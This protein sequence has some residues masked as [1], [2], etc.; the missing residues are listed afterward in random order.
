VGPSEIRGSASPNSVRPFD[1]NTTS[2]GN[3]VS[4]EST[5]K[6]IAAFILG[7]L[8][9]VTAVVAQTAHHAPSSP[10]RSPMSAVA[11]AP[12]PITVA[13]NAGDVEGFVYW[14]VNAITHNP[15]GSCSG[16][17]VNVSVAGAS[18]PPIQTG[19]H[20]KYA[21]QVKAFLYG[22]KQTI[23]DVCIYAYDHL[24]VGQ[25]LQARLVITQPNA[26]SPAVMA[27]TRTVSGITIINGQCNMLPAVTP[28]SVSDLTKPWGSCQNRAFDVNFALAPSGH[29]M[30]ASVPTG[31]MLSNVNNGAAT[32]AAGQ[33]SARGM[34]SGANNGTINPGPQQRTSSG[35]LAAVNPG[36][37]SNTSKTPGRLLP[38]KSGAATLRNADVINLVKGGVP[39][40]SIVN[41]IK[42]SNK[43]FDFSAQGCDALKRNRVSPGVLD[44]MGDG[45]ARPCFTGGVRTGTGNGADDLN[46]Q[47]FPPRSMPNRTGSNVLM[48]AAEQTPSSIQRGKTLASHIQLVPGPAIKISTATRRTL[49]S[50][51][52]NTI[53]SESVE[54]HNARVVLARGLSR[55][56]NTPMGSMHTLDGTTP[57]SG[58]SGD[59]QTGGS[60]PGGNPTGGQTGS[61]TGSGGPSAGSGLQVAGKPSTQIGSGS[62]NSFL[63]KIEKAP[64]PIS[65]CRFTTDPVI[66]TVAGKAH[67]IVLTPDPGSGQYPNNQYA[68]SGCNFGGTPGDVHIYGPFINNPSP[69]KLGID[70]WTDSSILV[71]FNPTFQNEYD[72][73]N[74]TLAVVRSDGKSVQIPGISFVATR[75]SRALASI[76]PSVVKLPTD[77]LEISKFVTPLTKTSLMQAGLN[78][79]PQTG[80]A[81][82]YLY[83]PIWSSNVGDGYPQNR[84]FF[85]DSIDLSNM[86]PGFS[87]DDNIQTLVLGYPS[88]D[89]GINSGSCKYF[90]TNVSASMQGSSLLVGV[91]PAECDEYG[92]FIFAYYGLVLSI[93]G[94][95][96]D[97]LNPWQDG[98]Q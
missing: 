59:G 67:D 57:A 69:V 46:P 97:K 49:D 32:P 4:K 76:P 5:R 51:I 54:T 84:L 63:Q 72:L 25:A 28:A 30:M 47:P 70:S 68:I 44:A 82:F 98:L 91:Q 13:A 6:C 35:T 95:K 26:F 58:G 8:L 78:P 93:T 48:S 66:Q 18:N 17:A 75:V 19:N 20:F 2:G 81:A 40:S 29:S 62:S 94:P 42:S 53:Q 52:T 80:T 11:Q 65:M 83:D 60:T 71:T 24:P 34:L 10:A 15:A 56:G 74:I 39:E 89:S 33:L 73:K 96:G 61:S 7:A 23:Y 85:S 27:Q 12:T 1:L 77:Y 43:Q 9:S 31:G 90:D 3:P 92:K 79:V 88:V 37:I 45:T 50:S 41:Q 55:S 87:L 21:G 14:D 38:A 36:P 64:Q 16:L 86:R 22:G